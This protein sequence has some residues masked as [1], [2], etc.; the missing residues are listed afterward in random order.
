MLKIFQVTLDV[1][2]NP[3]KGLHLCKF[4]HQVPSIKIYIDIYIYIYFLENNQAINDLV[5]NDVSLIFYLFLFFI[6]WCINTI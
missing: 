2:L 3:E 1:P 6:G 5:A 4:F